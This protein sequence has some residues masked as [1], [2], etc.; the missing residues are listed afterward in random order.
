MRESSLPRLPTK[1]NSSEKC[2]RLDCLER[3][4]D[5]PWCEHF[6]NKRVGLLF[7]NFRSAIFLHAFVCW[8]EWALRICTPNKYTD[9]TQFLIEWWAV[10]LFFWD[11]KQNKR[12]MEANWLHCRATSSN[13]FYTLVQTLHILWWWKASTVQDVVNYGKHNSPIHTQTLPSK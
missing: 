10:F 3:T 7:G 4:Y 2:G 9:I 11:A 1:N 13:V 12:R 8:L 5:I 6:S